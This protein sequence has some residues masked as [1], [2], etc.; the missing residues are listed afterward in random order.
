MKRLL[1]TV[2]TLVFCLSIFQIAYAQ[3][4]TREEA[5]AKTMEAVEM[6]QEE[7]KDA[8][9]EAINQKD[10]P[11]V[12]KDS[13]VFAFDVDKGT[14]VAHP[15][16]PGLIGK[17][18]MGLKDVDGKMFFAEFA[19]KAK[20]DGEGWVDYKWPKPGEK[21]PSPKDTYIYLVPG[22]SIMMGAGVYE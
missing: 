19:K 5:K 8:A 4:A 11:F 3:Q 17:D 13:Y 7:G 21:K 20:E 14:I 2:L 9:L 6:M 10:G 16:K 12:W 18:L 1:I 15:F 22:S